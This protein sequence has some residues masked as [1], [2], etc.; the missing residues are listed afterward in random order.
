MRW[1]QKLGHVAAVAAFCASVVGAVP[2]GDDGHNDGDQ[3][4]V[5]Q[6]CVDG[7]HERGPKF[8]MAA[9]MYHNHSTSAHDM[10]VT[11]EVHRPAT[12]AHGLASKGWLAV[13]SGA[14]MSGALM[15]VVYG[16]PVTGQGPFVSGRGVPL[17]RGHE[18]PHV[19]SQHDASQNSGV[20]VH[21]LSGEWRAGD[22]GT[23]VG[24]L[25]MA[26]YACNKWNG[27]AVSAEETS[28]AMIWAFNPT[29]DMA[30]YAWDQPLRKHVGVNGWGNFYANLEASTTHHADGAPAVV[31]G[32]KMIN[33]STSHITVAKPTFFQR[34]KARPV[35]HIHG[36]VMVLAFIVLFPLGVVGIRSGFTKAFKYH[37]TIQVAAVA[38]AATG[39][40]LGISMSAG[41]LF[42]SAHQ[43]IGLA[44]VALLLVQM[45]SGWWHHVLFVKIRRRTWVSY[46]HMSLGWAILLGGWA[47]VVTGS[48]LFGL[49]KTGLY[50]LA[51][52]IA[53]E[54]MALVALVYIARRKR[55]QDQ[56]QLKAKST[57]WREVGEEYFALDEV[58]SEDDED[59]SERKS[60][61]RLRP[62]KH[63]T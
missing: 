38:V 13:G 53:T 61:E 3:P 24:V 25:K 6:Y 35:A 46:G 59:V 4:A 56:E 45:A 18:Q 15:F 60:D 63:H 55:Q 26:C 41:N 20:L 17:Q 48:M 36:F 29:E 32:G 40:G 44:V 22:N 31:A 58:E 14:V 37:W 11:I 33:T 42:G 16:D 34:L 7:W 52:F 2:H 47:N 51:A 1:M 12:D 62:D 9:N 43:K 30:P 28:Q 49:G 8:C 39:A 10:L 54:L 19:L 50:A 27:H 57:D 21:Q 5:A 23:H